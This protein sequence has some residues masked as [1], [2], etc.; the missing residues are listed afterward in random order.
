MEEK[1]PLGECGSPVVLIDFWVDVTVDFEQVEPAVVVEIE[2]AVA[3]PDEGDGGLGYSGLVAHISKAGV[4]V[5]VI[6]DFV[7][8]TEVGDVEADEAVVL[9]VAGGN[10]HGGDF[11]AI[12]VER[13]AGNIA[14]IVEGAVAF[15]D[16]EEVG[17]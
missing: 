14:L 3:P 8:V 17:L 4:A 1:R 10:A 9:V 2:E 11:A 5:V 7:I 12:L 6:E 16:V 15:I 13:E